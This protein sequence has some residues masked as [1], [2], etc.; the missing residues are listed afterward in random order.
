MHVFGH[1]V[2]VVVV[3]IEAVGTN[4]TTMMKSICILNDVA[5][6]TGLTLVPRDPF[7]FFVCVCFVDEGGY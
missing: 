3:A 2:A 4:S 6:V 7:T 5:T 1:R